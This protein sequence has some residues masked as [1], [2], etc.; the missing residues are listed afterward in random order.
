MTTDPNAS[1]PNALASTVPGPP[2]HETVLHPSSPIEATLV[3]SENS[4]NGI[5]QSK[6]A[7]IGFLFLVTGA[8][9]LPLLWVNRRFNNVE[10]LFWTVAVLTWTFLLIGVTWAILRWTYEQ[11]Y[12]YL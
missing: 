2:F 8:V 1:D 4:A 6:F 3:R 12:P 11:I 5:S 10:R 7:V 9:G